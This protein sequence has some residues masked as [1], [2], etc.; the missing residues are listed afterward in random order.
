MHGLLSRPHDT[1]LPQASSF[2]F[3]LLWAC[4]L[5]KEKNYQ[6]S[7]S[8]LSLLFYHAQSLI[9]ELFV[10]HSYPLN[11]PL[12]FSLSLLPLL[13]LFLSFPFSLSLSPYP[14]LPLYHSFTIVSSILTIRYT[15]VFVCSEKMPSILFTSVFSSRIT[16]S[17]SLILTDA[18]LSA[19]DNSLSSLEVNFEAN[20]HVGECTLCWRHE[21]HRVRRP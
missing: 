21:N 3:L 6:I 9:P 2:S 19:T 4:A 13:A 11:P 7:S 12:S 1:E 14:S 5:F 8:L 16:Q 15:F 20:I 17:L 10:F 18:L